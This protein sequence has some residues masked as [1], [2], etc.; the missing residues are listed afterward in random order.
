MKKLKYEYKSI[1]SILLIIIAGV[2]IAVGFGFHSSNERVVYA[3]VDEGIDK[4]YQYEIENNE[5]FYKV[6]GYLSN[7]EPYVLSDS[8][9]FNS[10]IAL[11]DNDRCSQS[12]YADCEINFKDVTYNGNAFLSLEN[13]QYALSGNLDCFG[14]SIFGLIYI[15]NAE[16]I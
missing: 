11:I 7:G 1:L 13:G 5:M 2:F 15:N 8:A 3:D 9:T 4:V 12:I 14:Y 6:T 10:I 16:V